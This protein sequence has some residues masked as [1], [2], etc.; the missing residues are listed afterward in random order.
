[1]CLDLKLAD[2][3]VNGA[4]LTKKNIFKKILQPCEYVPDGSTHLL[5]NSQVAADITGLTK[6]MLILICGEI[7]DP[8]L[9]SALNKK[10]TGVLHWVAFHDLS[11]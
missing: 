9:A 11:V 6:V 4:R 2:R 10:M 3:Y 7:T 1:M 8:V 5:V